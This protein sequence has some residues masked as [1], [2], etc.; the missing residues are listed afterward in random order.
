M[1][2]HSARLE[3]LR[4]LLEM[5]PVIL[6]EKCVR[7]RM[8]YLQ[9]KQQSRPEEGVLSAEEFRTDAEALIQIG[10]IL[11]RIVEIENI[12]VQLKKLIT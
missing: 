2:Q 9:Q 7:N 5:H 8:E 6:P 12:E 10:Q 3:I 1:N 11:D 4:K